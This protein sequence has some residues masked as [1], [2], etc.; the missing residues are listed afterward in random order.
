MNPIRI[1][2]QSTDSIKATCDDILLK[3]RRHLDDPEYYLEVTRIKDFYWMA[4]G[5]LEAVLTI[6]CSSSAIVFAAEE[7]LDS[8]KNEYLSRL[9]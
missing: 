9:G 3:Y 7:R 1:Y 4:Y 8:I 5:S 6:F 2:D